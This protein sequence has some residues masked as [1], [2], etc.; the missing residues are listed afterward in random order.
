[1]TKILQNTATFYLTSE[2]LFQVEKIMKTDIRFLYFFPLSLLPEDS[3]FISWIEGNF[4]CIA[5]YLIFLLMNLLVFYCLCEI[6]VIL[7]IVWNKKISPLISV[8]MKSVFTICSCSLIWMVLFFIKNV[9]FPNFCYK[10]HSLLRWRSFLE[11]NKCYQYLTGT[12]W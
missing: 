3:Y 9:S 6:C 2:L 10:L 11:V 1:M 5:H 7:I 12:M 8:C 4:F